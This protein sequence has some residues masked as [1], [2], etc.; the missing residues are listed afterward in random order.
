VVDK[1]MVDR[2]T[3]QLRSTEVNRSTEVKRLTVDR[4]TGLQVDSRQVDKSTGGQVDGSMEVD[5]STEV[6]GQQVNRSTVDMSTG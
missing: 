1:S 4:L 5:R 3:G 6:D 2:L